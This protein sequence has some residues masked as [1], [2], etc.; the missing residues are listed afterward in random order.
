[1]DKVEKGLQ[2]VANHLEEQMYNLQRLVEKPRYEDLKQKHINS[3]RAIDNLIEID[4]RIARQRVWLRSNLNA[5]PEE[6]SK[7][8]SR[9]E[10]MKKAKSKLIDDY[11]QLQ[12]P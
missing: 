8:K 9:L 2:K 3:I 12:L 5:S 10:E 11:T 6:K 7:V 1:M 4:N